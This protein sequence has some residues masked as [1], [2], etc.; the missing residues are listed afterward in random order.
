MPTTLTE[1]LDD[2]LGPLVQADQGEL[3]I[4]DLEPHRVALHLRGRFSGCPGNDLVIQHIIEPALKAVA[5]QCR[6][7]ITSG[8]IIPEGAELWQQPKRNNPAPERT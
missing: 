3:Y 2:I 1:L 5:P 4:V 6:V 8:E 7:S